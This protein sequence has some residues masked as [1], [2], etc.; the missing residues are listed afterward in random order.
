MKL[1]SS[2]RLCVQHVLYSGGRTFFL[3]WWCIKHFMNFE[4]VDGELNPS[5]LV[6]CM[7]LVSLLML[8]LLIRALSFYHSLLSPSRRNPSNFD[9]SL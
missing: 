8:K 2:L 4:S 9:F 5:P 3:M 7:A 6:S 1:V